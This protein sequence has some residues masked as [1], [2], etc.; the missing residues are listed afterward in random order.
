MPRTFPARPIGADSDLATHI[1]LLVRPARMVLRPDGST[2]LEPAAEPGRI[3]K[4]NVTSPEQLGRVTRS[5]RAISAGSLPLLLSVNQEGGRLNA[6][7]WPGVAQLPGNLALGAAGDEGL[8][9]LA[10]AAIGEQLRAV[11]L[12][13]NLAPVCDTT[14]W[15]APAAVGTRSFGSDP[16]RVGPLAAAFVRGLQAA[17]VAATAKHFPGL[18]GVGADPHH[19]APVVDRLGPG[20]LLPFRAAID[21][22]VACVMVGSH[23]VLALDDQPAL[24][25]RRVLGLLRDELGFDG[26]VVSENL[27]IRAVHEP[28]GGVARAAVAAVAAGVDIVMLDSEVSRGRSPHVEWTAAV[29]RRAEVVHAL[30][31]AVEQGVID[32]RR[33]GEAVERVQ[34]LHQRY[35]LTAGAVQPQWPRANAAAR[36]VATRIADRSAAVLR[37]ARLLPLHV[38][39][40]KVLALVRV[41]DAGQR[42]ADSARHAQDHLP[43][44]LAA[45]HR[46]LQV[47]VGAP[48]P[49][50]GPVVVYGYDTRTTAGVSGAA[51]EATRLVECGRTVVQVALGDVDDLAGSPAPVLLAAFSPH[52]ASAAA[53]TRI[54]L[55]DGRPHGVVPVAGLPW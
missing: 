46:V 26:V 8:A 31:A 38:P 9:E 7:D 33:I 47:P 20:A 53:V 1:D 55:S 17:G 39:P 35:G 44:L 32:R 49:T 34:A 22:Q 27:S 54:L 51:Q 2:H 5:A 6:L 28:L 24:A 48:V 14:G 43:A 4:G 21:A 29:R 12:T 18:G 19:V 42:R 25:S 40:G 30:T 45:H 37:G 3:S 15:P 13:W 52:R 10:G 50:A 11:G 23:T 16:E 41:P 36:R